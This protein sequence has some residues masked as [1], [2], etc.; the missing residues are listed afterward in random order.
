[1]PDPRRDEKTTTPRPEPGGAE[2]LAPFRYALALFVLS[3]LWLFFYDPHTPQQLQAS[4]SL[5]LQNA[6]I[7]G[8]YLLVEIRLRRNGV[9]FSLAGLLAVYAVISLADLLLLK[10]L[11]TPLAQIVSILLATGSPLTAL[12]W[13]EITIPQAILGGVAVL[14]TFIVGGVIHRLLPRYALTEATRKR[15]HVAL[16]VLLTLYLFE[17]GTS[18]Y[19][20][21]YVSRTAVLPLYLRLLPASSTHSYTIR[22]AAPL[23]EDERL[24]VL[25]AIEPLPNPPHVL[26]IVLESFRADLVDPAVTPNLHRLSLES[27]TYPRAVTEAIL[28]S[29][30]WNVILMDRPGFMFHYDLRRAD[31]ESLGAWPLEILHRAGYEILVSSSTDMQANRFVRR[32]LG[33]GDTIAQFYM[34]FA[35]ADTMRNVWDNMATD[36]LVD[37]IGEL[38]AATP[39]FMLLQLDSTHWDYYFDE[40]A[41]I[42]RPYSK[43]VR[44]MTLRSQEALDLVYARYLNAAR[45]VDNTIGQVL[46]AL[47]VKGILDDTAIIVVSDH[48]EGFRVGQVGHSIL[49]RHTRSIPVIMK[50][51]GVEPGE[52]DAI[53][54]P[55]DIYPT[56]FEFLGLEAVPDRMLLG[57]SAL[58]PKRGEHAA[59]TFHGTGKQADLSLNEVVIRFDVRHNDR[60]ITF[61][62]IQVFDHE[63]QPL[64]SWEA[65][66]KSIPW[67]DILDR[68]IPS[69]RT[70]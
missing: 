50:L 54:S 56:L 40:D 3:N 7:V 70:P 11:S 2:C 14:L 63:D 19:S 48:G 9:R 34:A 68:L 41:I 51:P 20:S 60:D 33:T 17:H 66:L 44:P 59:L 15:F 43:I 37:W 35:P 57:A 5:L 64:E 49:H 52:H 39:H 53:I 69:H 4:L 62:P 16:A 25:D 55:R 6:L 42:A 18:R 36:T 28:T 22:M 29:L 61:T 21:A 26:Y 10:L 47:Q 67:R 65:H 24:R 1:M 45:Q 32:L 27:V 46:E 23:S 13:A 8:G 31:F 30:S 58:P 12:T 38:D